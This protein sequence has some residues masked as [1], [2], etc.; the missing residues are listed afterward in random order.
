MEEAWRR[1]L[2]SQPAPPL[3][4]VLGLAVVAAMLVLAPVAWPRTRHVV[5]L[6]HEGAPGLAAVLSGRRLAGIRLH[7]D[8]SGLTVSS[9]RPRGPGM[10]VTLAA[11]YVGPGLFGVG[12]AFLLGAGH[13]VGVLWL[14][15][16]LLV[17]LLAQIRNW[18]GLWSVLVTGTVLL[19]ASWWLP[20]RGQSALAY[21]VTWFLLLAAPRPVLELAAQRRR[22]RARVGGDSDADQL[23]RLTGVPAAV[24]IALFLAVTVGALLLGGH[25]LTVG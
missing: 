14:V 20:E 7:S 25:R 10:V 5:T 12:A 13:A 3:A 11:G 1:A 24:W 19:A 22:R 4:V 8:T 21:L 23:A 15:L 18:F 6:A 17:L 9:G 16:V 2:A